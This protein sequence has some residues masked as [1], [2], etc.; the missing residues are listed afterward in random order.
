M[1]SSVLV[2]IAIFVALDVLIL[3]YVFSRRKRG[4]SDM[5]KQNFLEHWRKI[6]SSPD[7]RHAVMDA[8]KLLDKM[9]ARKGY[10][11]QLG[12]K[13]KKADK[14]FSD[15]NGL[16]QAHKLRNRLAHELDFNPNPSEARNA[17][18]RFEEAYRDLGLFQ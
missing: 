15:I 14:V 5:D 3:V 10:G 18:R 7:L 2:F 4:F 16:W 17:L 1:D 13:L 12:E 11:G 9:L 6:Q 8:D